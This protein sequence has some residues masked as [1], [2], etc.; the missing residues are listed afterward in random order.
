M[1]EGDAGHLR[2]G[3]QLRPRNEQAAIFWNDRYPLGHAAMNEDDGWR[4]R[5]SIRWKIEV[6]MEGTILG[7]LVDEIGAR[8][9]TLHP[10]QR[11]NDSLFKHKDRHNS[12]VTN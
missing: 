10:R 3:N 12:M 2:D 5:G 7:G 8:C 11:K 1:V 4:G 9:E 6:G